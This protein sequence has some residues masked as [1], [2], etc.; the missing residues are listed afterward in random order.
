MLFAVTQTFAP[1]LLVSGLGAALRRTLERAHP[2]HPAGDGPG[3]LLPPFSCGGPQ[4]TSRYTNKHLAHNICMKN[5]Q[6]KWGKSTT[7]KYKSEVLYLGTGKD[8]LKKYFS[9]FSLSS[10][11]SKVPHRTL[12]GLNHCAQTQMCSLKP[13]KMDSWE[14]ENKQG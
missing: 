14:G 2:W 3:G 8:T 5:T 1:D 9:H 7:Q 4:Q 13:V 10:Q 6:V 11:N 12:N